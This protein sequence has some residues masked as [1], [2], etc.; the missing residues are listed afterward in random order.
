MSSIS[1]C[2]PSIGQ[3]PVIAVDSAR[4]CDIIS[5]SPLQAGAANVIMKSGDEVEM[6]LVSA[7]ILIANCPPS[8]WPMIPFGGMYS[9]NQGKQ[10]PI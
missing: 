6:A 9:M 7:A 1:R 8:E 2:M 4:A 5:E 10:S 3:L